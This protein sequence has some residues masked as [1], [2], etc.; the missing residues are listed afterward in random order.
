MQNLILIVLDLGKN[1]CNPFKNII[2]G[3]NKWGE[4]LKMKVLRKRTVENL[5]KRRRRMK[6]VNDC[7]RPKDEY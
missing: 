5:Y 2:R 6:D 7:K 4:E 1:S 3:T